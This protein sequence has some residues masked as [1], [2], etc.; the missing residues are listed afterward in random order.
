MKGNH[1][2]D[3]DVSVLAGMRKNVWSS[4]DGVIHKTINWYLLVRMQHQ[5][6]KASESGC[7]RVVRHVYPRS[8]V[9][10][11]HYTLIFVTQKLSYVKH[12]IY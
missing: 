2:G 10:F 7:V 9:N 6:V 11:E 1:I 4:R 5:R 3:V 8:V 12:L